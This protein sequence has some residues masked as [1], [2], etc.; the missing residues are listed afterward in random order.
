MSFS[1]A[2]ERVQRLHGE[3]GVNHRALLLAF[4]GCANPPQRMVPNSWSV[5]AANLYLS[6][7]RPSMMVSTKGTFFFGLLGP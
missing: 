7:P 3:F 1:V 6:T 2:S 4:S 5:A